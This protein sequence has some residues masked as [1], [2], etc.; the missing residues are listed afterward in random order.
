MIKLTLCC[1]QPGLNILGLWFIGEFFLQ[2][3]EELFGLADKPCIQI[4]LNLQKPV[5]HIILNI[6]KGLAVTLG[7]FAVRHF[8]RNRQ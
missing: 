2:C 1:Q 6:Q 4:S 8:L 5:F 7:I 3:M